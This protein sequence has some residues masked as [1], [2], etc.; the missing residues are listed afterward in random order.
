MPPKFPPPTT[1]EFFHPTYGIQ[2]HVAPPTILS[3]QM[4]ELFA[5]T[6]AVRLALS[7]HFPALHL[8]GDNT[9]ALSALLHLTGRPANYTQIRLLR[10]IYNMLWWSALPITLSWIPSAF[11]PADPPSRLYHRLAG[12]PISAILRATARY[13]FLPYTPF[14]KVIGSFTL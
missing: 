11:H 4:A 5:L 10:Q 12:P 1:W 2:V 9:G 13:Q 14:H 6:Y 8:V 7:I 3:Q